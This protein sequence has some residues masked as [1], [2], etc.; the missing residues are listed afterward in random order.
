MRCARGGGAHLLRRELAHRVP[1]RA[2]EHPSHPRGHADGHCEQQRKREAAEEDVAPV[3]AGDA[4]VRLEVLLAGFLRRVGG[5]IVGA[6]WLW[7][8]EN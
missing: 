5:Q 2:P 8:L 6:G 4:V 1:A 7:C 3:A